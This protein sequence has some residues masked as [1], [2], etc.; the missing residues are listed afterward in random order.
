MDTYQSVYEKFKALPGSQHIAGVVTLKRISEIVDELQ[1]KRVLELGAGI[2][3]ITYLLLATTNAHVDT[4][5][6]NEF[7]ISALTENLS[8]FKDRYTL[9][10]SYKQL[11]PE[12]AYDLVVIDGGAG[13]QDDTGYMRA[14]YLILLSLDTVR[15]VIVEG[16]RKGQNTY[17]RRALAERYVYKRKRENIDHGYTEYYLKKEK[18]LLKRIGLYF[19]WKLRLR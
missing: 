3:T 19:Y 12:S 18:S 11:P 17:V 16:H 8:G 15:V 9:L 5:E 2:G 14:A 7:C 10:T 4:Y 13:S 6:P 1:P